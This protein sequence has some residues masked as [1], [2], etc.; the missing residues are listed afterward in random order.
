MEFPS[1]DQRG[2]K[3]AAAPTSEQDLSFAEILLELRGL[4]LEC[5]SRSRR[6]RCSTLNLRWFPKRKRSKVTSKPP[7]AA[8]TAGTSSPDTPLIVT[9][10][11]G[12][13]DP[14]SGAENTACK[15]MSFKKATAELRLAVAEAQREKE[16]LQGE[17]ERLR[18]K[19]KRTK[20][21]N[22]ALKGKHM[23]LIIGR[24]SEKKAQLQKVNTCMTLGGLSSPS[25]GAL[26]DA[27]DVSEIL[28]PDPT[29]T[30]GAGDRARALQPGVALLNL[31]LGQPPLPD[32][33]LQPPEEN[34]VASN[35]RPLE[36]VVLDGSLFSRATAAAAARQRRYLINKAKLRR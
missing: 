22:I 23:A 28:A 14:K 24:E 16:C 21:L 30:I 18:R 6:R 19:M 5:E 35:S 27:L 12:S 4:F 11:G 26:F 7:I 20:A 13:S 9:Y 15:K 31:S 17:I 1:G 8:A 3:H 29:T 32:L 34:C 33:N 2:A 36:R 10:S 25:S